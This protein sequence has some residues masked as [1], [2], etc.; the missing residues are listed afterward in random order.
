LEPSFLIKS[1]LALQQTL[2]P[3]DKALHKQS[4]HW[5]WQQF[6]FLVFH[7]GAHWQHAAPSRQG[8][9]RLRETPSKPAPPSIRHGKDPAVPAANWQVPTQG[10][11]EPARTRETSGWPHAQNPPPAGPGALQAPWCPGS[12]Q[13]RMTDPSPA[14]DPPRFRG[15]LRG[16]WPGRHF[17]QALYSNGPTGF[18]GSAGRRMRA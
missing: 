8:G 4:F 9:A 12:A 15:P 3:S 13:A 14:L 5:A 16:K 11:L 1:N 18:M 6:R 2:R 10:H 17:H 7:G